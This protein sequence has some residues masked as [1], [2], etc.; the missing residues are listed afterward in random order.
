MN[1]FPLINW[2]IFFEELQFHWWFQAWSLAPPMLGGDRPP[3]LFDPVNKTFVEFQL[4]PNVITGVQGNTGLARLMV[5]L[6]SAHLIRDYSKVA[7]L[8]AP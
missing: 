7:K 2:K 6:Q 4:A 3:T 1:D 5:T 8:S